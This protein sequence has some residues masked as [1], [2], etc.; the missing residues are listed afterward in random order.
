MRERERDM[1]RVVVLPRREKGGGRV[2]EER[3][4][5]RDSPRDR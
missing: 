5:P 1:D 2:R 4:V 3:R